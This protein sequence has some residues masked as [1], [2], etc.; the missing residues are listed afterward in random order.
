MASLYVDRQGA[1]LT[2]S[3]G[4][5]Q[6]RLPDEPVRSLPVKI[7]QRVVLR[8]DTALS[9]G[10]IAALADHGIT[11]VM[12]G[13]RSGSR[14]AQVVG[15]P[16]NDCK[17]RIAQCQRLENS[18]WKLWW[19]RRIVQRRLQSQFRLI[20][21]AMAQRPDLRKPF[22]DAK[23]ALGNLLAVVG[24][25]A[26]VDSVRGLEG[27]GAAAYFRAYRCLFPDSAGFAARRRRPPPDPV[28]ACL[29]LGYT[30]LQS[31]AVESC[32]RV[33][34]DPAV[35]YLHSPT[36]GRDS[37]ACDLVEGWRAHIERWVWEAWRDKSLRVEHFGRD[38]SGACLLQK[39]GREFF[40]RYITSVL[41]DCQKGIHRQARAL[42][43]VLATDVRGLETD[44]E[45]SEFEDE[46]A[47]VGS[48]ALQ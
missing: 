35:G 19:S 21:S 12:F 3:A 25:A 23:G 34:L 2:L 11:L 40:Y 9:S 30:L 44:G 10:T 28:N 8:A 18:N 42:A 46:T 48:G 13:G 39:A 5:L 38:S 32:W 45:S 43:R 33:G 20:D 36:F 37:L 1:Q 47:P 29:S 16:S 14:V 15:L 4:V 41:T 6:V 26:T 17:V 31:R 22:F 27:A 7:I 24:K